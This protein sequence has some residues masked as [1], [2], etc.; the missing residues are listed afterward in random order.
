MA[1]RTWQDIV[2]EPAQRDL[3]LV[4][5]SNHPSYTVSADRARGSSNTHVAFNKL[6][7]IDIPYLERHWIRKQ[8]DT[9][10]IDLKAFFKVFVF[11][12]ES[13]VVNDDLCVRNSQF[14]N[15]VIDSFCRFNCANR[16]F[17]VYVK[18][19]QFQRFEKA[20]LDRESLHSGVRKCMTEINDNE[21]GRDS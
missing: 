3:E 15:P 18:R 7:Q 11:L 6:G 10:L 20:G 9:A 16:L 14:E 19:P 12:Q 2:P 21:H 5:S 8:F 4:R 17:K 1:C 13:R